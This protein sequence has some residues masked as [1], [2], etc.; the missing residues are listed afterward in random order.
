MPNDPLTIGVVGL[1]GTGRRVLEA[2]RRCDEVTIAA[3][4]DRD[5]DA[6]AESGVDAPVFTDHRSLLAE[7]R[8]QAVYV[9]L[10]PPAAVDV[11]ATCAQRGIA[12][13]KA[14]PLARNLAEA[15]AMV[16][17]MA[18]RGLTFMVATHRRF[19]R[20]YR[21]AI[22]QV[23]QVGPIFLAQAQYLFNWGPVVGWRSDVVTAG[24]GA[25]LELG[26][27]FVDLLTSMLGLPESVFGLN[28]ISGRPNQTDQNGRPMPPCTTDDTAA[29]VLRFNDGPMASL[30]T[31]RVSGPMNEQL[32]LHGQDGSLTADPQHCILRDPDGGLRDQTD[33]PT[34]ATDCLR[35]MIR[36]F[37][38]AVS[39]EAPAALCSARENLRN[40]A[41]MD[42][43]YLSEKTAAAEN[44]AALL[45]AAGAR[46]DDLTGPT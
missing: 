3:V 11:I 30:V 6:L 10:P 34:D 7:V 19:L 14:P 23:R 42:A 46:I 21:R 17:Q 2:M 43:L 32:A 29:A 20:S 45:R 38:G 44:P 31:S 9:S 26:Y 37:A 18:G 16:E 36:A 33:S 41:V 40:V 12:V 25:L 35:Q 28:A 13:L 4:A 8:P 1:D 22:E 39:G 24:G 27:H 15:T 5:P